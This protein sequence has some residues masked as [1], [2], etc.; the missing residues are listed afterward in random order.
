MN[1]VSLCSLKLRRIPNLA[2]LASELT[3]LTSLN[4]SKN[5]LFDGD[6][7]FS[8]LSHLPNLLKLNLSEN[9]LNGVLSEHAGALSQLEELNLDINNF[10]ALSPAVR[11]W[12]NLKTFSISDNSLTGLPLECSTWESIVV[13]NLKNNKISDIG[14]LPQFWPSLGRLFLGMNLLTAI[15]YE[16]GMCVMVTELDFSQ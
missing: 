12:T 2:N 8:A 16:I 7:V 6:E 14:T 15:P 13:V 3:S 5:N 1:E 9:Y 11:S 10:T 4:A